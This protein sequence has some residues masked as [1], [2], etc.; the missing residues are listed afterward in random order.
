MS[1]NTNTEPHPEKREEFIYAFAVKKKKI[2][3][4][5][6]YIKLKRCTRTQS[7]KGH[8]QTIKKALKDV[9]CEH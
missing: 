8:S 2:S 7:P 5:C 3:G 1:Q 4:G 9:H 6:K